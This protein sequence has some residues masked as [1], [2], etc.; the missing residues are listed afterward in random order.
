[1]S[2]YPVLIGAPTL[3]LLPSRQAKT[4]KRQEALNHPY[5]ITLRTALE[6]EDRILRSLVFAPL[7]FP[8][9]APAL[10]LAASLEVF[11]AALLDTAL[12]PAEL[13]K[14]RQRAR[15]AS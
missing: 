3:A 7:A 13:Q 1:M 8:L 10:L 15:S 14:S 12:L 11:T 5:A 2:G 4:Q 9:N 6:A